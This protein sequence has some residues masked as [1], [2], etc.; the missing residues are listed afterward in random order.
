MDAENFS[1]D[2]VIVCTVTVEDGYDG[3]AS[4]SA[5]VVIG[6][7]APVIGSTT[8]TPEEPYSYDSLTCAASEISDL[9]L[10]EVTISY[11]WSIDGEVQAET[12]DTL[13]GPLPLML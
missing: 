4:D 12:S 1:D 8:I 5:E 10:D 11:E 3:T 6:N 13:A 9:D 7:T 2:D